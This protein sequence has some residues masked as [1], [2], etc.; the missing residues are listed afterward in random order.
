M[1]DD[2]PGRSDALVTESLEAL[3]EALAGRYAIER[4]LGRG[5]MAIVYL[6]VDIKH[7]RRVAIKVL[8]PELASSV[9]SARF[10]REIRLEAR[11]Q[12]PNIVSLID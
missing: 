6:A 2:S 7:D 1:R 5:G 10:L 3:Q 8:R 12:H 9:G 4:E 11:L